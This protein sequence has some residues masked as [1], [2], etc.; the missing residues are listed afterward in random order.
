MGGL[1]TVSE[2]EFVAVAIAAVAAQRLGDNVEAAVLDRLARKINAA[3]SRAQQ[4]PG[5]MSL[6]QTGPGFSWR[7]V[8]SVLNGDEA[9]T[10][11][12]GEG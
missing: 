2:R 4:I 5:A 10:G 6:R 7:D 1:V 3:L 12:G 9:P 8:P 11:P